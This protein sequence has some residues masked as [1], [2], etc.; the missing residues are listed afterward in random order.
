MFINCL[1][2]I[3]E[4]L[5]PLRVV[6]CLYHIQF[7]IMK[8]CSIDFDNLQIN[9]Q[10]HYDDILINST[11]QT[12]D[13]LNSK[14]LPKQNFASYIFQYVI[15]WSICFFLEI[16]LKVFLINYSKENAFVIQDILK[17]NKSLQKKTSNVIQIML[18][19]QKILFYKLLCIC[20]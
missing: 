12:F 10:T 16:L 20:L 3:I 19:G 2:Q 5:F 9:Y 15:H 1:N 17:R 7:S 13:N 8:S 4:Y 18:W 6:V 11:L 14:F